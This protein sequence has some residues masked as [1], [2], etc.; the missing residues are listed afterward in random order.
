MENKKSFPKAFF[1][2]IIFTLLTVKTAWAWDGNG[3]Q[4]SPYL[5]KTTDDLVTLATNSQT[6]AYEDRYFRLENDL[7]MNGVTIGTIG[8]NGMNFQGTFDGNGHVIR[9]LTINK[10]D[11]E[12]VGLFGS[13]IRGYIKFLILDGATITGRNLVGSIV[14]YGTSNGTIEN[15]LVVNSSVTATETK[16]VGIFC[17]RLAKSCTY[18]GNFYYNC[19]ATTISTTN[20]TDIG[21]YNGDKIGANIATVLV[22]VTL[23]DAWVALGAN[24]FVV[25][26]IYY[27]GNV[28]TTDASSV[29]I[30]P[31]TW[32][33]LQTAFTNASTDANNPTVLTLLADITATNSDA[34][35]NLPSGCHVILDLNG[36]TIDR[37]MTEAT[38]DGWVI[39]V[40]SGASLTIRD[41]AGGGTITGGW[42]T[43]SG[44][45]IVSS[46]AT[47][48][49][50]GG[51]ISGC[52]TTNQGGSAIK[53][54]GTLRISGGTI[55]GNIANTGN[56]NGA[57]AATI[58][59]SGTSNFYLSDGSI[60]GNYCGYTNAGTAGIASELGYG[61]STLH[62]SGN[63]TLSGNR[64]GTY[65][66]DHDTWTDLT[67]SDLHNSARI[68]VTI[69]D[70]IGPSEPA[71]L[72]LN[73]YGIDNWKATFTSGW[74]THMDGLNPE[75]YFTLVDN[76]KVIRVVDG[77]AKIGTPHVITLDYHITSSTA[78]AIEGMAVTL[79]YSIVLPDGYTV[80]YYA[81][82]GGND[83]TATA[84][85]GNILT[86]PD[87]DVTIT[88]PIT[89]VEDY[90]ALTIIGDENGKT[91]V[92]D[93]ASDIRIELGEDIEVKTVVYNRTFTVG[94]ASTVILPFDY[95]Y[96]KDIYGGI[97]YRFDDVVYDNTEG[98]WV[99]N[100]TRVGGNDY[101]AGLQ[102]EISAHTPY[103]YM[104][105][106]THMSFYDIV[107]LKSTQGNET[108]SS[109]GSNDAWRFTGSYGMKEWDSDSDDYGFAAVAGKATDGVT[110]IEAGQ[111]VR[112]TGDGVNNAFIKPMRCYLSYVGS[113][114]APK[115]GRAQENLPQVL[116]VR[117]K[118]SNGSTTDIGTI[119]LKNGTFHMDIWYDLT[120]R[121][122]DCKPSV[123]GIY[124]HN[125][126]KVVIE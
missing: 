47:L 7:D 34:Y 14:G 26:G 13:I 126:Q 39:K 57:M 88:V 41:T 46:S 15:C 42:S 112:F 20:T 37:N 8:I 71:A 84:I 62:L 90:G 48:N 87:E 55:T 30:G 110:D 106:D 31:V 32:P 104:P 5:I 115:R 75:D 49:I 125:G 65:D 19:S 100:M 60:S 69:D 83:I 93:A 86:M 121:M 1:V 45:G 64:M 35:L 22:P 50:E 103:L 123:K 40:N 113:Q 80:R 74:S 89:T 117:L 97:F 107:T 6:N 29:T 85:S 54:S 56:N 116:T 68:T 3:T 23:P 12:Q 78:E 66:A 43:F 36:H 96:W 9:N 124:I 58:Y 17:G 53:A 72:V 67:A 59:L 10:P 24:H 76:S 119:D 94:R 108:F 109:T 82:A 63:Y 70:I 73:N 77:E 16:N 2:L 105:N 44:A 28:Y 102:Y 118:R 111:F 25:G 52:R 21:T 99:V 101:E 33:A 79:G 61:A 38:S 4:S 98:K 122:L 120:G 114:N 51:T 81:E 11:E 95:N 27:N 91:A 18:N 92:F